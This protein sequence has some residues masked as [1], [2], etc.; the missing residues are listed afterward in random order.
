MIWVILIEV[1][2][3]SRSIGGVFVD[4]NCWVIIAYIVAIAR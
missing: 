3:Q 4:D 2:V 1:L